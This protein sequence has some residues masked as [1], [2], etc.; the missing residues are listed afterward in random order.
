[1]RP[2][3]PLLLAISTAVLLAA[4]ASP[5]TQPGGASPG[6]TAERVTAEQ[7]GEQLMVALRDEDY[8]AAYAILSTGRARDVADD[9]TD[10]ETRIEADQLVPATW[11]FDPL[12]YGS[13]DSGSFVLLDGD[14]TFADGETG[15][16]AMKMQALGLQANPWR[17]EEFSLE[18]G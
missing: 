10:L 14:V 17:V 4:C 16:V 18:R 12:G 7:V 13:D 1:M 8:E 6:A 3:R 15:S 11:T 9:A 2:L 5:N